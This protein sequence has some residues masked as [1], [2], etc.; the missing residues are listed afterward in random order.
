MVLFHRSFVLRECRGE[1]NCVC[2]FGQLWGGV[3][4]CF[5]TSV[6]EWRHLQIVQLW[7]WSSPI[8]LW[9]QRNM[10]RQEP[11]H[12][13]N[14][15]RTRFSQTD[16]QCTD[17]PSH[18]ATYVASGSIGQIAKLR[19]SKQYHVF[20]NG[21]SEQ[22]MT[23]KLD[24]SIQ[25]KRFGNW[26]YD[27]STAVCKGKKFGYL[28]WFNLCFLLQSWHA[29]R[30]SWLRGQHL[31]TQIGQSILLS[32]SNVQKDTKLQVLVLTQWNLHASKVW[33]PCK[34]PGALNGKI[35][36]VSP[37]NNF[38]INSPSFLFS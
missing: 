37:S 13:I 21:D 33:S 6:P 26:S 1:Y 35:A 30:V 2:W 32:S 4:L 25:G 27:A 14:N 23:C 15:S 7:K 11:L 9:S 8:L 34:L 36:R 12:T 17:L 20:V 18:L 29:L 24:E 31:A 3:H 38:G 16:V 19:C 10:L 22:S 28:S 5:R